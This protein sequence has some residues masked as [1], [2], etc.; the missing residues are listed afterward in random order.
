M[1]RSK[2]I[3][4]LLIIAIAL[5]CMVFSA[6]ADTWYVEN[7]WNY[8][9][10]AME[11]DQGIPEDADGALARIKRKGVLRVAVSFDCP[12]M[13]YLIP[14]AEGEARYAGVD[15]ELA[16][17][18]AEKMGVKLV[19]V[20]IESVYRL[21]ALTEDLCDLTIS[22]VSYTPGRALYYTLS[23]AYYYPDLEP[24]IGILIQEGESVQSLTDLQNKIIVAQSES[25]QEV[26][27]A[28]EIDDYLEFRRV[29]S[30]R[31]VFD[32]V[33]NGNAYA[34]IVSI[35]TA[36]SYFQKIPDSG[37]QLAENG[38]KRLRFKPDQ[39]YLGYRVAA[40][41]GETKLIAFVNGVINEAQEQG[42][43]ENWLQ[44]AV[45]RNTESGQE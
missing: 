4:Q 41:R 18:I 26:F 19:I 42:A 24:D 6:G 1:C 30:A 21:P 22:A 40:Q 29:A 44:S 32:M 35:N 34:G 3:R 8:L 14:D 20:P 10:T 2:R 23:K 13:N 25:I 27:A 15:V 16:R 7:E 31:T 28:N 5:C 37:L 36:D 45:D 12:P 43:V 33:K 11:V 9:D 39:Q 38:G 17:L